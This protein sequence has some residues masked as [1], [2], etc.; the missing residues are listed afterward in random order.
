M[1]FMVLNSVSEDPGFGSE[2]GSSMSVC[3]PLSVMLVLAA[4]PR[5]ASPTVSRTTTSPKPAVHSWRN[6][7]PSATR[8]D[9]DVVNDQLY[10]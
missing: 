5:T 10:S 9:N 7:S 4:A 8:R 1:T 2:S 3:E 6:H